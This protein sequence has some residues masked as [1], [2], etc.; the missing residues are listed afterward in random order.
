M[1]APSA[2]DMHRMHIFLPPATKRQVFKIAQKQ[3]VSASEL[4]RRAVQEYVE[5]TSK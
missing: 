3:G 1:A 4:V 5:K 2:S